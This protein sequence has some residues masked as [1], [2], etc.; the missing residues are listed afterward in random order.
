MADH[1]DIDSGVV[2]RWQGQDLDLS[3]PLTSNLIA[4][5]VRVE[6]RIGPYALDYFAM[7]GLPSTLR[8]AEPLARAV[9]ET[10]WRPPLAEGPSRDELVELIAPH[11]AGAPPAPVESVREVLSPPPS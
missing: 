9:Y 4:D 5:A 8:P 3:R 2:K 1:I 10:G 7:T 11:S 6:P